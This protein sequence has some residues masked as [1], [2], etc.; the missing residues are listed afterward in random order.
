VIG[1][2]SDRSEQLTLSGDTL[3]STRTGSQIGNGA[4]LSGEQFSIGGSDTGRGFDKQSLNSDTGM[5]G[6][7]ELQSP[8]MSPLYHLLKGRMDDDLRL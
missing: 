6:S 2:S 8:P 7:I 3:L 4:L 1:I 5:L